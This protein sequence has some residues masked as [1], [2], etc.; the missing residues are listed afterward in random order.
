MQLFPQSPKPST[1]VSNS[2]EVV[3][4]LDMSNQM[5]SSILGKGENKPDTTSNVEVMVSLD[6]DELSESP[7]PG[8][9][10]DHEDQESR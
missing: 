6:L 10:L 3:T 1:A 5:V 4:S 2:E 7:I 9:Q 8:F